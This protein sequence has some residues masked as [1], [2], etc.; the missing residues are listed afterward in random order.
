MPDNS[1]SRIGNW[2][3]DLKDYAGC[4]YKKYTGINNEH[5][6]FV[7]YNEKVFDKIIEK[8]KTYRGLFHGL[9]KTDH[10]DRHKIVVGIMLAATDR[11]NL[12]FQTDD[13]AIMNSSITYVPYWLTYP[14]E[15][16]LCKILLNI[17]TDCVLTTKKNTRHSLS[18]ENYS[19]RFPDKIIRWEENII[20][21][22]ENQFCRLLSTLI[23][24]DNM[25]VKCS[26]LASHLMFFYELAYDCAVKGLS[27][28]Y[29]NV[30]V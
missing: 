12:I 4:F 18:K 2:W 5:K 28:V 16:F 22:Y 9:I 20:E 6:S 10:I 24:N 17:L 8:Y 23:E 3:D 7:K 21:P 13:E 15:Y 11:E 19:I 14:N 25:S 27:R 30:A 29:Y 1:E 26:L